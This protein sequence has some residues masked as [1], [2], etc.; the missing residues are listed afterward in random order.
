VG[1]SIR[2]FVTPRSLLLV[3]RR[4]TPWRVSQRP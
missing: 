4:R 2:P 3:A 1:G